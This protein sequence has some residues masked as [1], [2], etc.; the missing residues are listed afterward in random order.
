MESINPPVF[1]TWTTDVPPSPTTN[2]VSVSQSYVIAEA[3][4]A[5][6][7]LA[8]GTVRVGSGRS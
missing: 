4:C 3:S 2:S 8:G 5:S 1:D 7:L 6:R